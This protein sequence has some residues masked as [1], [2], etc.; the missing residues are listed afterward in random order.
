MKKTNKEF[1]AWLGNRLK[2]KYQEEPEIL[3]SFYGLFNNH[4]FIKRH[5][6]TEFIDNI[7][8]EFYPDFDIDRC[9]DLN[10]GY[11]EMEREHMR[12]MIISTINKL[13]EI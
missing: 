4:I 11:T 12:K 7:C 13:I 10:I 1:I 9:S 6:T 2:N 8:K 3:D 5:I